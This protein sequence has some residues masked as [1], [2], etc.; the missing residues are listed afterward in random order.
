MNDEPAMNCEVC[1]EELNIGVW[2]M[3]GGQWVCERCYWQ[4]S[5]SI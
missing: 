4:F 3:A 5:E 1:G 2:K